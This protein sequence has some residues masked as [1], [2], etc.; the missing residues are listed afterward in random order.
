MAG[1]Q[2]A[3]SAGNLLVVSPSRVKVLAHRT[4]RFYGRKMIAGH[5]YVILSRGTGGVELPASS[6]I[7]GRHAVCA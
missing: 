6:R 4:G 1:R 5:L 2:A 3:D 7:R